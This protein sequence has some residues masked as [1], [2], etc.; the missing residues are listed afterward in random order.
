MAQAREFAE[1]QSDPRHLSRDPEVFPL[2]DPGQLLNTSQLLLLRTATLGEEGSGSDDTTSLT[3]EGEYGP[4]WV[5]LVE[6]VR[7]LWVIPG[8][9]DHPNSGCNKEVV[10]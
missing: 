5:W 7:S 3:S 9:S 6:H 4:K 2:W 1:N 8:Y 10:A